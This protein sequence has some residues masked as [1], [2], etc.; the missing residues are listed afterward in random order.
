[1]EKINI[2][3]EII[4]KCSEYEKD[5]M[6]VYRYKHENSLKKWVFIWYAYAT[7]LWISPVTLIV[8]FIIYKHYMFAI[9][10][11]AY[12]LILTAIVINFGMSFILGKEYRGWQTLSDAIEQW[13]DDNI[14]N[15]K[16]P[17]PKEETD[18]QKYKRLT[19]EQEKRDNYIL[20]CKR[21]TEDEDFRIA[22]LGLNTNENTKPLQKV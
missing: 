13:Y 11:I 1:M 19:K 20:F 22:F 8:M 16:E 3:Q 4:S 5:N 17:K 9:I 14:L 21:L 2:P 12:I 15:E 7:L 10:F 6:W 18:K